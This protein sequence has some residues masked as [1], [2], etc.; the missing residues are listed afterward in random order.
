V[1][2]FLLFYLPAEISQVTDAA[3]E[4]FLVFSCTRNYADKFT[5]N[6]IAVESLQQLSDPAL[7]LIKTCGTTDLSSVWCERLKVLATPVGAL[8]T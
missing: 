7:R 4:V 6:P 5:G 8:F 3:L 2:S 1:I